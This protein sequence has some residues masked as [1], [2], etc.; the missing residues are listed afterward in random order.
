ML[1]VSDY[2]VLCILGGFKVDGAQCF[3]LQFCV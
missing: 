2:S 1:S 3:R